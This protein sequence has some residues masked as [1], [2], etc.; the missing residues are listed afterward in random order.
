MNREEIIELSNNYKTPEEI[1]ILED[2]FSDPRNINPQKET[3]AFTVI[4]KTGTSWH[5]I[6]EPMLSFYR[7]TDEFNLLYC[8]NGVNP[9]IYN[10]SSL[11]IDHRA[12]DASDFFLNIRKFSSLDKKRP[13]V[14]HSCDDNESLLA[15]SHPLFHIWAAANRA[16]QS[17]RAI[18]DSDG[19]ETTTRKL[20]QY[21]QNYNKNVFIQ[22]NY[23]NFKL[24]QWNLKKKQQLTDFVELKPSTFNDNPWSVEDQKEHF[25]FP[26]EW[27]GKV[28]LGYIGLTSHFEDLKKLAPMM[29]KIHDKY[30]QTVFIIAGSAL[31]DS[32]FMIEKD[33]NTGKDIVKETPITNFKDTY[34]YR[35]KELFSGI[36][37]DR[38][39]FYRA[40]PL[41]QF[42]WFSSLCDINF[43][44]IEQNTFNA[45]KSE[46]KVVE[47]ARYGNVSIY[48]D[49][50]GYADYNHILKTEGKFSSE[51][52]SS[53][54]CRSECD[55]EEWVSKI[56][57]WVER[58][59]SEEYLLF[60]E[61]LRNFV[62][63]YYEIDNHIGER[64]SKYK[65]LIE[66]QMES[67]HIRITKMNG[68]LE[69]GY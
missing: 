14:L 20:Q 48:S 54:S 36:A 17:I 43:S 15:K 62:T 19:V 35:V 58:V 2:Y 66:A 68:E 22:R 38:I 69:V 45:A 41:E 1:K 11:I 51:E 61:R 39:K 60:S 59:N 21:C 23:F 30:P 7:K 46:I 47:A 49:F 8:H 64:I 32:M 56:S 67:E 4:S 50:G 10:V 3:I 42:G 18:S 52:I 16:K 63:N 24:P 44:L 26:K 31:K 40:L 28:V 53:M 29:K 27:K 57:Y 37:E 25:Y 33:P 5:R 6:E 34:E 13:I 9:S 65:G 55:H 12:S